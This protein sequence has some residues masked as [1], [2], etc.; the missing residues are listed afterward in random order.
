[1]LRYKFV[2]LVFQNG[3][4]DQE[5]ETILSYETPEALTAALLAHAAQ[6]SRVNLSPLVMPLYSDGNVP[7][8]GPVRQGFG[9]ET[10]LVI[11]SVVPV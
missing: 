4:L 8:P 9:P 6:Q 5:I 2:F 1:M 11:K 3:R 10:A 7:M